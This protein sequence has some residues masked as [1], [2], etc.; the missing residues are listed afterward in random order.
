MVTTLV[1]SDGSNFNLDLRFWFYQYM[2]VRLSVF[3]V[4]MCKLFAG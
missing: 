4:I 3:D 1:D 2:D